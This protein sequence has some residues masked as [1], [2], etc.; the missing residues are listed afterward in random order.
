M[1]SKKQKGLIYTTE[2]CKFLLYLYL[3]CYKC[4]RKW[5]IIRCKWDGA[6]LSNKVISDTLCFGESGNFKIS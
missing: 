5:F 3:F 2:K 1:T 4:N 6:F